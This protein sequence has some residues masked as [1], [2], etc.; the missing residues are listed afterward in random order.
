MKRQIKG[1]KNY[2][3]IRFPDPL[4]KKKRVVCMCKPISRIRGK[5]PQELLEICNQ[6]DTVPVD[7]KAMLNKLNISCVAFD[8]SAFDEARKQEGVSVED[9][10]TLGA[11]VTNGDSAVIFYRKQDQEEGH[12]Y[13]FTIAHELAHACLDHYNIGESS[14]HLAYRKKNSSNDSIEYAANVFAGRLLI[15]RV[16]LEAVMSKLIHPTIESLA[17]IFEV[18]QNV[19]RSRLKFLE[20]YDIRME[21]NC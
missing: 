11:L 9:D 19:M 18:S 20:I 21:S 8:F 10:P 2:R 17:S 16:T 14:V 12:R 5:E 13:R 1:N 7:L 4:E 15:P 3:L 6:K